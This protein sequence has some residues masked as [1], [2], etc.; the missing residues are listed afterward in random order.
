MSE[1]Q[2]SAEHH[3]A[4]MALT[5][6]ELIEKMVGAA[7]ELKIAQSDL[8]TAR[9]RLYECEEYGAQARVMIEAVMERWYH[10]SD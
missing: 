9:S 5:K 7:I 10:Y 2:I 3:K 1:V 8:K 6:P 4:L